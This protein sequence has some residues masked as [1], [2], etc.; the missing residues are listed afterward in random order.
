MG[1]LCSQQYFS[2]LKKEG[3]IFVENLSALAKEWKDS[4]KLRPEAVTGS[5]ILYLHVFGQ[6]N[7]MFIRGNH[8]SCF[9]VVPAIICCYK[10]YWFWKHRGVRQLR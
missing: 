2:L 6:G 7:F 1:P 5:D 9:V 10:R 3:I 4:Y 8:D